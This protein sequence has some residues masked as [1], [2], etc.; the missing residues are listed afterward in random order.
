[1]HAHASLALSSATHRRRLPSASWRVLAGGL[2]R[3]GDLALVAAT[4]LVAGAWQPSDAGMLSAELVGIVVGCLVAGH[5]FPLLGLYRPSRLADLGFQSTRLVLA[6]LVT[7]LAVGAVLHG[8]GLLEGVAGRWLSAWLLAGAVALGAA[9]LLLWLA[10]TR[11]DAAQAMTRRVAVVGAGGLLVETLQRLG[12]GADPSL[13]LAAVLDLD[14]ALLDRWP[15]GVVALRDLAEIEGRVADGSIERVLLALPA[16][17]PTLRR[18]L[19]DLRHLPIDID[20]TPGLPGEGQ[21]APCCG[22]AGGLPLVRLASRPIDGGR[23]L[24]KAIEDRVLAGLILVLV[25]PVMTLIALAVK[26]TS[27]GPVF[28][29]QFRRGFNQEAISVLK[30]RTMRVDACD[31]P[32]AKSFRQATRGDP[33]VTPLGRLLRRTS[34]DE[35][36]QLINVARGEMSLV[37]PRPHPIALDEKYA[38][39]IDGYLCRHRVKPGITGWAQVNGCRGETAD[40]AAMLRRIHYDL[41]YIQNWSL[42]FDLKILWMTIFRGFVSPNAY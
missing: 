15:Q 5:A 35:L 19:K 9:R 39:R 3:V 26:L 32:D 36:P 12:E 22:Q 27:P 42:L 21:G 38:E 7:T 24:L 29:R 25:A 37:G 13:R 30:F 16:G 33:R 17:S 8:L 10:L 2:V 1:M 6:W 40:D 11:T 23:Y 4:G 20:W 14:A 41:D 31:A 18:S 34:L 28:Y